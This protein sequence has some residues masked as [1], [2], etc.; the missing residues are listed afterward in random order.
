M[1][2]CPTGLAL[3]DAKVG[4]IGYDELK[5]AINGHE[6]HACPDFMQAYN[7]LVLLGD[8]KELVDE[9]PR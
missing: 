7:L 4:K 6:N 2:N 3:R 5:A 8:L 9:N 1:C